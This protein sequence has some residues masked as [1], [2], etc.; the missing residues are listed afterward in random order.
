M[1]GHAPVP[2]FG[3]PWTRGMTVDQRFDLYARYLDMARIWKDNAVAARQDLLAGRKVVIALRQPTSTASNKGR[4]VYDD[5]I[6]I[7]SPGRFPGLVDLGA[8]RVD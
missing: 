3:M 8:Q 7:E 5:R 6:V 4:G 2:L 1:S